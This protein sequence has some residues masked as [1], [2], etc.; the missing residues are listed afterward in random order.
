M[1]YELLERIIKEPA[2]IQK[3]VDDRPFILVIN[4]MD[5]MCDRTQWLQ[6]YDKISKDVDLMLLAGQNNKLYEE[7][8]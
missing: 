5:N 2:G 8:R 6:L 3:S 1:T 7:I 4:Q